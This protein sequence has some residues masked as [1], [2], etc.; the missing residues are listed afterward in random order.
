MTQLR[1]TTPSHFTKGNYFCDFL[2]AS[3][4][5]KTL[6]KECPL[7]REIIPLGVDS[8]EME[9]RNENDRVASP[10]SGPIHLPY[11]FSYKTGFPFY[12]MTTHN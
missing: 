5:D 6:E 10:A 8:L 11:L 1:E 3:L 12:R 4:E 9:G 2:F 7:L